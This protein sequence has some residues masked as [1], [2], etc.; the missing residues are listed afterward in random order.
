MIIEKI[1]QI[2][3]IN[4]SRSHLKLLEENRCKAIDRAKKIEVFLAEKGREIGKLERV[5]LLALWHKLM[6]SKAASLEVARKHYLSMM[7]EYNGLKKSIAG[8]D[9]EI[10][11]LAA[12]QI[13]FDDLTTEL[14]ELIEQS[15]KLV[16]NN[17]IREFRQV[18][19]E[20][21]LRF[22]LMQEIQGSHR[23]GSDSK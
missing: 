20:L 19:S 9:F 6:G 16:A 2:K 1:Q 11:V 7:L 13:K 10:S 17:K 18:I 4:K 8:L 14:K 12:Q 3:S 15:E 21:Q 22:G 23:S 5:S